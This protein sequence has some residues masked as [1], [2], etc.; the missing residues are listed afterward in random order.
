MP[1]YDMTCPKCQHSQEYQARWTDVGYVSCTKCGHQPLEVKP[2]KAN[3]T[4]NG[5][6]EKNGY[7]AK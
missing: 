3:F 6:S 2:N 4:I 7:S 5:Y 1:R